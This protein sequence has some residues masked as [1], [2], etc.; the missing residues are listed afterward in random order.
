MVVAPLFGERLASTMK[1]AGFTVRKLAKKSGVDKGTITEWRRGG[2]RAVSVD[3]VRKVASAMA[4]SAEELLDLPAVVDSQRPVA[5]KA[6]P[7]MPVIDRV[8]QLREELTTWV[9][10][11]RRAGTPE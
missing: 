5:V 8:E 1:S 6:P 10:D 3:A 7:L 2:D 4:T 11:A 9:A